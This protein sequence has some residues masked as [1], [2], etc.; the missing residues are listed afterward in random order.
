MKNNYIDNQEF[1]RELEG[2][3]DSAPA[4]EDR[5]PSERLGQLLMTLHDH[6]LTHKNFNRYNQDLKDEMKSYSLFRILKCGLKSYKFDGSSPFSY[7]T[8]A[9]FQNYITVI[10]R[11]YRKLNQKQEY[12]KGQLARLETNGNPKLEWLIDHF[13]ISGES[14]E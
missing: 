6:I 3:R 14:D 13:G 5:M 8:R 1:M 10:M 12:V 9:V 2:W 11:Y 7:F 4:V